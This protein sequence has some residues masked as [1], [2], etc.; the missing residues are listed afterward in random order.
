MR[1][2]IIADIHSNLEALNAVLTALDERRVDAYLSTGDIVGYGADPV[3]CV[4]RV[5]G[6]G[7]RVVAGNHDWAAVGRLSLDYFN[8]YAREAIYWTQERLSPAHLRFLSELELT[9]RVDD[10][11]IV[12]GT[13][14]DPDNFDYLLKRLESEGFDS[15]VKLLRA[16]H[17]RL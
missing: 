8:A 12:H 9:A 3:A 17:H 4:D 5:L 11:T 13:L 2:G 14:Y 10:I 1:Y 15:R 7:A 16:S 6:I